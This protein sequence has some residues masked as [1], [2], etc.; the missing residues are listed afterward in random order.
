MANTGELGGIKI[1]AKRNTTPTLTYGG[2]TSD[3]YY[4]VELDSNGKAFV[5][6]PWTGGGSGG[7]TED[8]ALT[9]S[10]IDTILANAT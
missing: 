1:S 3:R 9:N 10:E 7:L 6:V 8:D 4:G 2:T 5:N